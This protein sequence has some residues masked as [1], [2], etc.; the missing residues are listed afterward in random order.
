MFNPVYQKVAKEIREHFGS[1]F[2]SRSDLFGQKDVPVPMW[3]YSYCLISKNEYYFGDETKYERYKDFTEEE[4]DN[5][6]SQVFK[7]YGKLVIRRSELLAM[8][9]LGISIPSWARHDRISGHGEVSFEKDFTPWCPIEFKE[10]KKDNMDFQ[11]SSGNDVPTR[12][13][14]EPRTELVSPTITPVVDEP[15]NLDSLLGDSSPIAIADPMVQ[16]PLPTNAPM[17]VFDD[18]TINKMANAFASAFKGGETPS[19]PEAP[20]NFY[21]PDADKLFI[22]WGIYSDIE[23]ILERGMFYPVFITGL[24]G[25]GKTMG[26]EQACANLNKELIVTNITQETDEDDLLGGYRLIDGSTVWQDGPVI[27]AMKRGCPLLLDE[28][29]YGSS[30]L[31]CLQSVLSGKPVLIKKTGKYVKPKSGFTVFATANTKGQGDENG[32]FAG[33]NILNEAFLDRF[34]VMLHNPYPPKKT[35]LAIFLRALEQFRFMYDGGKELN[36]MDRDF[37]KRLV[38]WC[39]TIRNSHANGAIEDVIS[40]RRGVDILRAFVIFADRG[41]AIKIGVERFNEETRMSFAKLYK[42]VDEQIANA[43]KVV[44][45]APTSKDARQ[46]AMEAASKK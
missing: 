14:T 21:I 19:V 1:E 12:K 18:E 26:I 2:V 43:D 7:I 37:C 24:S 29:D 16:Y 27:I 33:T 6:A 10:V 5:F 25:N 44:N 3:V 15:M 40:T 45:R 20:K 38:Q 42:A 4:F 22:K 36:N 31:A 32:K 35:E 39:D 23:K 46:R 13:T 41:R 34:P 28:I 17:P 11:T 30:K 9:K 8:S